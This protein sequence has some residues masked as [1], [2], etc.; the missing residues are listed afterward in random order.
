ME[1]LR[2]RPVGSKPE[3]LTDDDFQNWFPHFSPDGQWIVL[4]SCLPE[5][6][7]AEHPFYKQVYIRKMSAEG[8]RPRDIAYL[9]GRQGAINAPSCSPDGKRIAFVSNTVVE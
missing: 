7:A 1:L 5:V 8:D 6:P 9:Y 3:Q 2:R 4:L